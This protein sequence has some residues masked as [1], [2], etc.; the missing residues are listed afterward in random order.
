MLLILTSCFQ[1]FENQMM[2]PF[3]KKMGFEPG[4]KPMNSVIQVIH[5]CY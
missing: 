5:N 2:I 4:N 3:Y 1:S